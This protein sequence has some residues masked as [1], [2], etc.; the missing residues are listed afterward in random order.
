MAIVHLVV[1]IPAS[2]LFKARVE[3]GKDRAKRLKQEKSAR[4]LAATSEKELKDLGDATARV[5]K[6]KRQVMDFTVFKEVRFLILVLLSFFVANGY[7]NPYYFFPS[8][9]L[10]LCFATVHALVNFVVC[11]AYTAFSYLICLFLYPI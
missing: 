6:P 1:L 11:T 9:H 3:S 7:F 4:E 8:K 10:L 5:P 2:A